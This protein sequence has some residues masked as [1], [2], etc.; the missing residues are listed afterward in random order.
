[1]RVSRRDGVAF[2][3]GEEM[4]KYEGTPRSERTENE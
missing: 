1:V 2:W 4:K 3:G